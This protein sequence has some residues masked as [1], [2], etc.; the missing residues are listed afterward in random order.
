MSDWKTLV[1]TC[2]GLLSADTEPSSPSR[3]SK[4]VHIIIDGISQEFFMHTRMRTCRRLMREGISFS[5]CTTIWPS[6]TGPAH[7]AINSGSPPAVNGVNRNF[8]ISEGSRH[9][10][11]PLKES[12]VESIAEILGSHGLRTAGICGQMNRGLQYYVSEAYLGHH[13]EHITRAA[14]DAWN[15]Y[16]PQYLQVVYFAVDTIQHAFGP[17]SSEA[18]ETAHWVDEQIGLLLDQIQDEHVVVLI[19]ADHGQTS[20]AVHAEEIDSLLAG[21]SAVIES[22]G[23]FLLYHTGSSTVD[24]ELAGRLKQLSCVQ[25]VIKPSDAISCFPDDYAVVL[26]DGYSHYQQN[27]VH[28]RWNHGGLSN[29]EM[30]VPLII[31]GSGITPHVVSDAASVLDIAPTI[32]E[33]LHI[34]PPE[35]MQGRILTSRTEMPEEHVA[36]S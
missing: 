13:A 21:S 26:T 28:Y 35:T 32:C 10:V 27:D 7:T 3:S 17:H 11:N 19:S 25:Q 36:R 6:L 16:S 4:V 31:S 2:S 15:R 33:L 30:Q 18:A 1:T 5:D 22:H 8:F 23:R 29:L 20:A 9:V 12:R 34:T 14:I 24:Q